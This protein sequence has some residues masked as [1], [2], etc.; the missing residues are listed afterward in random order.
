MKFSN[1]HN[2]VFYKRLN[3]KKIS[4]NEEFAQC[5]DLM[6]KASLSLKSI[7]YSLSWG[8]FDNLTVMGV[9]HAV[10]IT[11]ASKDELEQIIRSETIL[12]IGGNVK[13]IFDKEH[14]C[15]TKAYIRGRG[16]VFD[17]DKVKLKFNCLSYEE[18]IKLK[19]IAKEP[20][21]LKIEESF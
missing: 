7:D 18:Y 8:F 21:G 11:E 4:K 9:D 17:R 20:Y 10:D 1:Y 13:F 3:K 12:D 2:V 6:K 16:A 5:V 15:Y 14:D 19:E